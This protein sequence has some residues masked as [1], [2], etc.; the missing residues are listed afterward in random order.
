[1][2][3]D[4][5]TCVVEGAGGDQPRANQE[6]AGV[7]GHDDVGRDNPGPSAIMWTGRQPC[8]R[9]RRIYL[10]FNATAPLVRRGACRDGDGAWRRS[11]TRRRSTPRAAGRAIASSAHGT[12]SPRAGR[13]AARAGRVHERRHRGATCWACAALAAVAERR[14]LPRVVAT[15]A[16]EHPSLRGAVAALAR[17]A[18]ASGRS[19]SAATELPTRA[20]PAGLVAVAAVN[21]ELGTIADV[22]AIA[23]SARAAGALVHVDAVQAAGKLAARAARRRRDRDLGAQAR[24]P[25]GRRRARDRRTTTALP[26]VDGRPPGARPPPR[27]REHRSASS[28][29]APRRPAVDLAD[30]GRGRRARRS[31]RGRP[32]S[33]SSARAST[34]RRAADRR[35][36]QRRRSPA[37]AASRS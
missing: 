22:A 29:S 25:A 7:V 16:I 31:A 32:A 3:G 19:G 9:T 21:H 24:R 35:H 10:D 18:G 36:D 27:H 6:R 1:M 28:G 15:T 20:S 12:R 4:A 23:A 2:L 17:R 14:G 8:Q 13:P 37:R 34:A 5:R 33:R 11:A 30:V 26:L